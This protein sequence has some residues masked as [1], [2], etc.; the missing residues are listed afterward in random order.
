MFASSRSGIAVV[1]FSLLFV[2]AGCQPE[3]AKVVEPPPPEVTVSQPIEREV[4]D[5][6][7]F[8]GYTAAVDSVE[9]RARV[10]G[11]LTKIVAKEGEEV[12][13]GQ[14]L[15]QID[16]EPFLAELR[17]ADAEV[18]KWQAALARTDANLKRTKK[19][20]P[21]GAKTEE[22]LEEAIAE[23]GVN[24][25][26]LAAAKTAVE[27]AKLDLGYTQIRA[28]FA[29]RVGRNNV[30]IGNLIA[31]GQVVL[32]TLVAMDPM[33]VYFNM[34]E[35]TL[36]RCI[37]DQ[38][39]NG[40]KSGSPA[41]LKDRKIPVRI[42]LANDV[43]HPHVGVIDFADNQVDPSTGTILIR[44]VFPNKERRLAPG[45]FV[46]VRVDYGKPVKSLL[47]SDRAVGTDQGQKF[48]LGVD[49]K[50][51]VQYRSVKLGPLREGLRVVETGLTAGEWIVVNGL[52]R[53]R[54]GITVQARKAPMPLPAAAETAA[55]V[56]PVSASKPT[57]KE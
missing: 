13:E 51:V 25:A 31:P 20:R 46:N 4:A 17:R 44:G 54:P 19:L 33:Y 1:G 30:S 26:S 9:L 2:Q 10:A 49:D 6:F 39:G 12:A 23:K 28:P 32:T 27:K 34:D 21:S 43:G 37:E 35:P 5:Y 18:E 52:Q 57:G 48:L 15:F 38:R 42:G 53:A 22:D 29:G 3:P 7:E 56:T 41:K 45:L 8:T 14:G 16:P 55:K 11:Y 36:L 40:A 47:V 24:E 50:N